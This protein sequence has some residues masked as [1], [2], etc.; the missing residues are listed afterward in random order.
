M[1]L[2]VAQSGMVWWHLSMVESS[3]S[4]SGVVAD[5]PGVLLQVVGERAEPME[6]FHLMSLVRGLAQQRSLYGGVHL[7]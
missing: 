1:L 4:V 6:E 3:R 5:W 2:A 7:G